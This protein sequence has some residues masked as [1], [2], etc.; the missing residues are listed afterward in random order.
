MG[1]GDQYFEKLQ[2]EKDDLIKY[3]ILD[4][5]GVLDVI[6]ELSI[7][8]SNAVISQGSENDKMKLKEIATSMDDIH[9]F[10]DE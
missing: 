10:R 7:K 2:E 8:E 6:E 4:L 5:L 1:N 9:K 3:A